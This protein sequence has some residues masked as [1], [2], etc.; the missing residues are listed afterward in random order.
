M[1]PTPDV[2]LAF[3]RKMREI[4]DEFEASQ[5]ALRLRHAARKEK[6]ASEAPEGPSAS[7]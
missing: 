5:E 1:N 3:A 6:E 4:E 2:D 7:E